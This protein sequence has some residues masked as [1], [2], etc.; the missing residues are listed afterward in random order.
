M[1]RIVLWGIPRRRSAGLSSPDYSRRKIR[2][3][4]AEQGDHSVQSLARLSCWESPAKP[5]R[6]WYRPTRFARGSFAGAQDDGRRGR[7]RS[8]IIRAGASVITDFS[9]QN[10]SGRETM[11]QRAVVAPL[12]HEGRRI[13]VGEAA[14]RIET[15]P[16]PDSSQAQNDTFG[17]PSSRVLRLP[18]GSTPSRSL[19]AA[20]KRFLA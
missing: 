20:S 17:P 14:E 8:R 7:I 6:R 12:S 9:C 19:R 5:A 15:L 4:E 16:D 1:L 13:G 10:S 2:H 18:S 3:S 11:R